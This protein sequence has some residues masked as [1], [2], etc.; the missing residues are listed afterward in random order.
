MSRQMTRVYTS[1][2]KVATFVQ[3]QP[4]AR[5]GGMSIGTPFMSALLQTDGKF[6]PKTGVSRVAML[7][8]AEHGDTTTKNII[9]IT[10]CNDSTETQW[11]SVSRGLLFA[12]EQGERNI[13]IEN[14]NFG[15]V[16]NLILRDNVLK[17]EYAKHYR[18][19][20]LN[21]A[22]KTLW[23]GIRWIPR[24]MNKADA[25]LRLKPSKAT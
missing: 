10:Q 16:A 19:I 25:L 11:A 17:Q 2:K 22:S 24:E 5:I 4:Y 1:A 7:L 9:D 15:V 14:D 12:I 18:Y 13:T 6:Y 8:K 3:L 23:T 20:I 21:L